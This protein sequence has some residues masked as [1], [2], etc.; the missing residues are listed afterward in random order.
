MSINRRMRNGLRLLFAHTRGRA[1]W[2]RIA[3][4]AAFVVCAAGVPARGQAV[5]VR[6]G[7]INATITV[8]FTVAPPARSSVSCGLGLASNDALAPTEGQ[9]AQA[10]VVGS[11]ATCNIVMHYR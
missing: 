4:I 3:A 8:Q 7:K 2:A 11:K 10:A 1:R 9:S 6:A 5:F